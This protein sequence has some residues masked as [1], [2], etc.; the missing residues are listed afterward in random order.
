[1]TSNTENKMKSSR[2]SMQFASS[3][4][5][6]LKKASTEEAET[7]LSNCNAKIVLK[8]SDSAGEE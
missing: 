6:Q 3:D 1:M 8:N 4:I 2:A 7:I 5:S